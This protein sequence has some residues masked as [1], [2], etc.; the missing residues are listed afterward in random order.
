MA[1]TGE[2]YGQALLHLARKRVDLLNDDIRLLL[3]T[4][5]YTFDKDGHDFADDLT[6][7]LPTAGGYTAGGISLANKTVT[8]DTST[9][10]TVFD[11]DDISIPSST[12][13]WRKASV[14]DWTPATAATR[15]LLV[16]QASDAD[17]VS[18][19]GTTTITMPATG[20]IRLAS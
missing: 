9:N 15:P 19:G 13:T 8:Y 6:N 5:A 1:F 3:L 11:A 16:Y 18:S 17:I 14:V 2:L 4:N 10:V 7:E 20:I 12:L